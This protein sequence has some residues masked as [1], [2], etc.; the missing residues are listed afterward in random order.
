MLENDNKDEILRLRLRMTA[1]LENDNKDEI[2]RQRL[3][4]TALLEDDSLSAVTLHVNYAYPT[5]S[6]SI[7]WEYVRNNRFY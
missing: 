1:L 3:R 7:W 6:I 2:L 5:I 4:M